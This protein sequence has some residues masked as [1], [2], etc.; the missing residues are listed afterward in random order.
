MERQDRDKERI[1]ALRTEPSD[2]WVKILWQHLQ[3]DI[4]W[5]K[6]QGWRS[7]QWVLLLL[8]ALATTA[9]KIPSWILIPAAFIVGVVGVYYQCDLH[10]FAKR[11][12]TPSD[13][14]LN[15]VRGRQLFP[16]PN[17]DPD[18]CRFLVIRVGLI[19]VAVSFSMYWSLASS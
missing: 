13:K 11:A 15:H 12:R 2:D 1:D 17:G 3:S 5:A 9:T 6:E 10:E 4:R 7:L 18:H 8:A 16:E 19:L 14:I